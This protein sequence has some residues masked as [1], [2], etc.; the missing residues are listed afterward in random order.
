MYCISMINSIAMLGALVSSKPEKSLAVF[1]KVD[2]PEITVTVAINQEV[3]P[4]LRVLEI[5]SNLRITFLCGG[6]KIAWKYWGTPP[7]Q[8]EAYPEE[9]LPQIDSEETKDSQECGRYRC[10]PHSSAEPF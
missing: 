5:G 1:Q 10:E 8:I 7:P 4:G 6:E 9:E 2:S 3:F